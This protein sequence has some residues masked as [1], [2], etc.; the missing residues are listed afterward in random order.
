MI[1]YLGATHRPLSARM[2]ES[3]RR[4]FHLVDRC[5]AVR[6]WQGQLCSYQPETHSAWKPS[7]VNAYQEG[8]GESGQLYRCTRRDNRAVAKVRRRNQTG[9]I[10]TVRRARFRANGRPFTSGANSGDLPFLAIS[11]TTLEE[12]SRDMTANRSVASSVIFVVQPPL[13]THSA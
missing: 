5:S 13:A 12:N 10:Q 7:G 8:F 3:H 6:K 4:G 9:R 1:G 11:R 2:P